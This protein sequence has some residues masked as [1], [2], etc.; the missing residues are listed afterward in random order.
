MRCDFLVDAIEELIEIH[1]FACLV[2]SLIVIFPL[3]LLVG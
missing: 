2:W 3:G 1:S